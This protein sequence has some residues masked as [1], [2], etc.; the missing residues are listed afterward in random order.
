MTM[1]RWLDTCD[2]C[3]ADIPPEAPA[4]LCE[5]CEDARARDDDAARRG[6]EYETYP[7]WDDDWR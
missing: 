2:G 4:G 7:W 3:G 1:T 6:Y 5:A